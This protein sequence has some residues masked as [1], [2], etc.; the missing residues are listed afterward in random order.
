MTAVNPNVT[1]AAAAVK[2]DLR[3]FAIFDST[4][5]PIGSPSAPSLAQCQGSRKFRN[6]AF[7]NCSVDYVIVLCSS[8]PF[9]LAEIG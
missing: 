7:M 4:P 1:A 5:V 6:L 2:M 8:F 9:A 3:T